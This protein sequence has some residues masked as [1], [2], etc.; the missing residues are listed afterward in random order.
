MAPYIE[1]VPSD[2]NPPRAV[3]VVVVGGG[4]IGVSTAYFLA[5]KGASV[6]LVEKGEIAG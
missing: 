6:A 2:S 4:V 1:T 3:D 5:G